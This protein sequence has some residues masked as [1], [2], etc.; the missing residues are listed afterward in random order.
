M[1]CH[2]FLPW[3]TFCQNSPLWPVHLGWPGM[4][5]LIASL[6]YT[7]PFTMTRLWSMKEKEHHSHFLSCYHFGACH[8]YILSGLFQYFLT[9]HNFYFPWATTVI[10]HRTAKT[11]LW[12]LKTYYVTF[13][14]KAFYSFSS[15]CVMGISYQWPIGLFCD[16]PNMLLT[17]GLST[18]CVLGWFNA[19]P[20]IFMTNFFMLFRYLLR[21]I[22]VTFLVALFKPQSCLHLF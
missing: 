19:F 20:G 17:S 4:S 15:Y 5:W 3:A 14:L 8:N 16:T 21:C 12:K 1:V 7:S 22:S 13:L 2:S 6:S 18:L 9:V 11:I 10:S